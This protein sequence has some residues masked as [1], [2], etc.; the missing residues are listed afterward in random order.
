[1]I[2]GSVRV[3]LRHMGSVGHVV[4]D[5]DTGTS[6]NAVGVVV[7]GPNFSS[8]RVISVSPALLKPTRAVGIVNGLGNDVSILVV[9]ID[10]KNNSWAFD[11]SGG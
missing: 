3:V 7:V 6:Q 1:M 9:G 4:I 5:R 11:H 2:N 8:L 10:G